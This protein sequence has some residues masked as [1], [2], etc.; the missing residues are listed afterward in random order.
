[1]IQLKTGQKNM[2]RIFQK[3]LNISDHQGNANQNL[4]EVSPHICQNDY[5]QKDKKQQVL[6]RMWRKGTLLHS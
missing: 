6:T 1:M 4:S 5:H 2:D 3:M